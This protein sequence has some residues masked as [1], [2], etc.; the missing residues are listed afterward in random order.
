MR[1]NPT[2]LFLKKGKRK[3]K[4]NHNSRET[5]GSGYVG[6]AL[7]ALCGIGL[8]SAFFAMGSVTQFTPDYRGGGLLF[9][10][11]AIS[12]GLLLNGLLRK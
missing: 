7:V 12:F 9:I 8:A 10:A 3:M 2:R 6:L 11:S 1:R 4:D 5:P